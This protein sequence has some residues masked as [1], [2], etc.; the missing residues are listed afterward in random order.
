MDYCYTLI[1]C[2]MLRLSIRVKVRVRVIVR[3]RRLLQA[4]PPLPLRLSLHPERLCGPYHR[5]SLSSLA[6][7]ETTAA[8]LLPPACLRSPDCR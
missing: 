7:V 5:Q 8:L 1:H 2:N 4:A 3:V 6:Q